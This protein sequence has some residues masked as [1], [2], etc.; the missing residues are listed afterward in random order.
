MAIR[1][2]LQYNS[3]KVKNSPKLHFVTYVLPALLLAFAFNIPKFFETKLVKVSI[4]DSATN[5]TIFIIMTK[6]VKVNLLDS[7]TNIT[8]SIILIIMTKLVKANL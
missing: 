8:I 4:L 1:R 7:A 2:P 6:L 5:I 3:A